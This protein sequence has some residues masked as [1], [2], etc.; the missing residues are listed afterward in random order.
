M[1]EDEKIN[2][3]SANFFP[4]ISPNL[5]LYWKYEEFE[6]ICLQIIFIII[7]FPV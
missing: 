5:F 4:H 1:K 3:S 2:S 7:Y 6:N